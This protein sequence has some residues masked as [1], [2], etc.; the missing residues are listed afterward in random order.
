[1]RDNTDRAG[2]RCGITVISLLLF[3][4]IIWGPVNTM[5]IGPWIYE[6]TVIGSFDWRKAWVLNGWILFSPIA[7]A[8]GYCVFTMTRAMR[9]DEIDRESK[10]AAQ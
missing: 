4:L 8:F 6:G 9:K 2:I 3:L 1:M 10:R 7:L 5:W